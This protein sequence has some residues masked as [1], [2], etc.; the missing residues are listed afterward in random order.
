MKFLIAVGL[1]II[2]ITT[3]AQQL[4]I[5]PDFI[6][7]S[8][9]EIVLP[10]SENAY[11]LVKDSTAYVYNIDA[12]LPFKKSTIN[13]NFILDL[14]NNRLIG[15]ALIP[16]YF[17]NVDEN[18]EVVTTVSYKY[19]INYSVIDSIESSNLLKNY[20]YFI[21]KSVV[22]KTVKHNGTL[23]PKDLY[24]SAFDQSSD[25]LA[26]PSHYIKIDQDNVLAAL[27]NGYLVLSEAK[28]NKVTQK[29]Y[30]GN[31]NGTLSLQR[32]VK[33][34]DFAR[35][36][37]QRYR[38]DIDTLETFWSILD[39]KKQIFVPVDLEQFYSNVENLGEQDIS[40]LNSTLLFY[41]ALNNN[42]IKMYVL[43]DNNFVW[44]NDESY[45]YG[46]KDVS[47]YATFKKD[48]I[49][50]KLHVHAQTYNHPARILRAIAPQETEKIKELSKKY[51]LNKN[52]KN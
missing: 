51:E 44:L 20:Q 42:N 31:F 29:K 19:E 43:P 2:T 24:A 22:P 23:N 7:Q 32:S 38:E 36:T 37:F 41:R 46:S 14:K 28:N 15:V 27:N 33:I 48:D 13:E 5:N 25:N 34:G 39:L 4:K 47:Q 3:Q 16:E 8:A 10:V 49:N 26:L 45:Y 18:R 6:A 11:V 35:I 52:R 30:W 17:D 12:V 9:E 40:L 21:P 1:L 50:Y